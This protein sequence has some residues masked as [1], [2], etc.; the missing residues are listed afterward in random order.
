LGSRSISS[1]RACEIASRIVIFA[2]C[3]SSDQ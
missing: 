3:N 2:M 1:I